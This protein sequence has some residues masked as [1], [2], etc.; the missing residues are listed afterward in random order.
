[1]RVAVGRVS[2]GATLEP[3][4]TTSPDAGWFSYVALGSLRLPNGLRLEAGDS[5]RASGAEQLTGLAEDDL[6]VI[7]VELIPAASGQ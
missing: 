4:T 1:M 6:E 2:G 5:A 7:L 3:P